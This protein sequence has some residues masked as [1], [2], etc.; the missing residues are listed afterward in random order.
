MLKDD[1]KKKKEDKDRKK[2]TRSTV[3]TISSHSSNGSHSKST[4]SKVSPS[5][6]LRKALSRKRLS[7]DHMGGCEPPL[8]ESS[9]EF[10]N[11]KNAIKLQQ[12]WESIQQTVE[13]YELRV[14]EEVFLSMLEINPSIRQTM[15]VTSLRSAEFDIVCKRIT[16]YIQALVN[17]AGPSISLEFSTLDL[18]EGLEQ[19]KIPPSLFADSVSIAMKKI[20][21][22]VRYT[23]EVADAWGFFFV[24]HVARMTRD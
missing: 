8:V 22:E 18:G 6:T 23:E 19:D 3:E 21:G 12:S 16:G 15:G 24:K 2:S 5:K 10:V 14:G 1:K 4:A 7:V 17:S 13:D 11:P 20:I 9:M